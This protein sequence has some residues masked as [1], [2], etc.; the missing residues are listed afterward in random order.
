[1]DTDPSTLKPIKTSEPPTTTCIKYYF[2]YEIS[3]AIKQAYVNYCQSLFTESSGYI[4]NGCIT[5]SDASGGF[6][7]PGYILNSFFK[8]DSSLCYTTT[9]TNDIIKS[10]YDLDSSENSGS[11]SYTIC[12]TANRLCETTSSTLSSIFNNST[13]AFLFMFFTIVLL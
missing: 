13:F 11:I 4:S 7:P 5:C 12:A 8:C 3:D 2:N 10:L 6:L 9:E 1:M